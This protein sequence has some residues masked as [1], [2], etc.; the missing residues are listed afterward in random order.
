MFFGVPHIDWELTLHQNSIQAE[1]TWK[2]LDSDVSL[3]LAVRP[4]S[5]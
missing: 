4:E 5:V 3:M 1:A 2:E